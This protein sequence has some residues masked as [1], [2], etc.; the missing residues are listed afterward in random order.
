MY[1]RN[2]VFV[3]LIIKKRSIIQLQKY[4]NC[5][6]HNFCNSEFYKYRIIQI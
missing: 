5:K 4:S 2:N 6:I 1:F 3:F